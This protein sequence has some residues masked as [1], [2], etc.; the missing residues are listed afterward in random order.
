MQPNLNT[1]SRTVSQG[2]IMLRYWICFHILHAVE[3][4]QNSNR[5]VAGFG[6]GKLLADADTGSAVELFPC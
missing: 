3:A 1:V 5:N 4:L 2:E 6:Q